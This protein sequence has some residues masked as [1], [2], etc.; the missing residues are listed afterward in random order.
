MNYSPPTPRDVQRLLWEVAQNP[1]KRG[2]VQVRALDSLSRMFDLFPRDKHRGYFACDLEPQPL[3]PNKDP[4][5]V[6]KLP[7]DQLNL[8][9]KAQVEAAEQAKQQTE[10]N[11]EEEED[12]SNPDEDEPP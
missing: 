10:D 4:I 12:P 9:I 1:G 3:D 5:I 2:Y 8:V 7:D 6:A 11:E